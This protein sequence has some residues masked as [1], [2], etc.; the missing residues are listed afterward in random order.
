MKIFAC[1]NWQLK[2]LGPILDRWREDGHEVEYRL[3]YD[4][5]LHEWA[6]VCFVD[7]CDHNAVVGSR[8]RFAGSRL[9]IRAIDIE[10]WAGQPGGVTWDNVDALVFGAKHIQELVQGYARI[11]DSVEIH[12][13]PFGVDLNKWTYRERGHGF[14]VACVA[15]RWSAKGLPLLYQLMAKLGPGYR[16]HLLGTRNT[17]K[18]LHAYLDH[19]V[20]ELGLDVT[21]TD[22]VDDVDAWLEDKDYHVLASAKETFSYATAEAAAKGIKP[23]VHNFYR[24][25][26]VWPDEWI[27][28]TLDEAVGMI[29]GDYDSVGYRRY[30]E[31]YYN[32]DRMM[33]GLNTACEIGG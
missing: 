25:R 3:G 1:C 8:E 7:V 17:E 13:V 30:V 11:P 4:P 31:E 32:L 14:N 24:A 10:C 2:F 18:W 22:R 5:A 6:D 29:G 27:W 26:D 19:M 12:H 28:N 21:E 16:L 23:L 9:V 33:R 20:D 15:H